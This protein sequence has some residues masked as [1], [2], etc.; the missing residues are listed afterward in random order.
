MKMMSYKKVNN[1]YKVRDHEREEVI[2]PYMKNETE[3]DF[4]CAQRLGKKEDQLIKIKVPFVN[5]WLVW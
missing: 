1:R 4:I 5:L 2:L 3:R